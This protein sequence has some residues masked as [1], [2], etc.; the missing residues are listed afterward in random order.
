MAGKMSGF[1][2]RGGRRVV[3]ESVIEAFAWQTLVIVEL[4]GIDQIR[5]VCADLSCKERK[6]SKLGHF[7]G[8]GEEYLLLLVIEINFIIRC[9][10]YSS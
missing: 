3:H 4:I 2:G 1:G 8:N 7:Y 9:I 6:R 5:P 10:Y